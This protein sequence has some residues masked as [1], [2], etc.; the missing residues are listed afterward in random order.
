M[1]TINAVN[2]SLSGQT[3]TNK[4]VGS[5]APLFDD[6]QQFTGNA[7]Q[8]IKD[9][10]G[11]VVFGYIGVASGVNSIYALNAI[12]GASPALVAQGSDTNILAL[13]QGKGNA[14]CGIQGCST[15]SAAAAG[16]V[17]QVISSIVGPIA[18]TSTIALNV[19]SISLTAGDWVVSGAFLV[20]PT[21]TISALFCGLSTTSATLGSLPTYTSVQ[22][23][24]MLNAQGYPTP[25]LHIS[26]PTTT[27]LYLVAQSTFTATQTIYGSI[28]ARRVR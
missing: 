27:T 16:Y 28:I 5:T 9:V 15:N 13:L 8:Q 20:V 26:V 14:G 24:N 1:A 19:T 17:G 2:T 7:G 10:N 25:T 3:G 6:F 21:G 18:M 4:F 22:G 11:A 12:A 23:F